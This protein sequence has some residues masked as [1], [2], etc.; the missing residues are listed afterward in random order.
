MLSKSELIFVLR[1]SGNIERCHNVPHH[2]SYSVG[3]HSYGVANIILVLHPDPTIRLVR[4]ALWHDSPERYLG[5]LPAPAKWYNPKMAEEYSLA[6]DQVISRMGLDDPLFHLTS[7]EEKWLKGADRLDLLF[8]CREQHSMGNA[9]VSVVYDN[10]M[11]WYK[12]NQAG[13]P[14]SIQQFFDC[15]TRDLKRGEDL[16][17]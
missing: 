4:A 5:D 17:R 11:L 15:S 6:E 3:L 16:I 12:D 7:D 1:E 9:N 10:L 14:Y 13:L 2:G 8:W